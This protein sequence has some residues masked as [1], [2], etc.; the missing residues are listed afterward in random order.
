MT[1][2]R[3]SFLDDERLKLLLFGG[4]GGVGKT[5]MAAAT[6]LYQARRRPDWRILAASTDPAHSLSDSFNQHIG[7]EVMPIT[8]LPNLFAHE[9]NAERHGEEFK[10]RHEE[11]LK[12]IL[13]R[14]TY[15]DQEDIA[16]FL[17]LSLPGLDELMAVV[18]VADI[19][20]EKQYNLVILDTAP[21]GHTLRL[22]ALPQ[23]LEEWLHV[24]DLMLDKHRYI[25]STFGRVRHDEA[26]S[27]L[28][29]MA[30]KLDRLRAVLSDE[31]ST[32]FVPVTIPE[33]MSI[34]ETADLL[35]SLESLQIGVRSLVVNQV[36][37][38][39]E[40]AFCETRHKGQERYLEEIKNRFS[41][42]TPVPAPLMP[43]EVRGQQ[44][45]EEYIQA[46]LG[47]ELPI[48]QPQAI[49]LCEIENE[50]GGIS[51]V[52]RQ[53]L[54]LFGG[55]GGV[56]K[57]TIATATAIHL[58]RKNPGQKNL[59]FSTDPAHSLSDSLGQQ[60]G[61]QITAV[62]GVEGLFALELDAGEQLEE[63]KRDYRTAINELFDAFLGDSFDI[64][65]D[66]LVMEELITLTPPGLDEL[67]GLTTIMDFLEKGE[68]DHYIM[69]MAPTGHALRF[70][71]MPGLV[72]KWFITMFK[73]LLKYQDVTQLP[74]AAELLQKKSKHL[75]RLQKLLNDPESCQLIAVTIP[76]TMAV[77][78]TER[79]LHQLDDL[80][81]PC[82]RVV[83]NMVM[84]QTKCPFCSI[85][86][87]EQRHSLKNLHDLCPDLV[88]V[89]LQ[90]HEIRGVADLANI[91]KTLYGGS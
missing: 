20:E 71:E 59:L 91:A 81:V 14:G 69:D 76:Q 55:K 73:L 56:G 41:A 23:L 60:I 42:C 35:K 30:A 84:P 51:I 65:Y 12:T 67:M 68:F 39:S 48:P 54:F 22:L 88:Q 74:G 21:T 79:L 33:A 49:P 87:D 19:V 89:P 16:G 44:A 40:C 80:S 52:E 11:V 57:T 83:V 63:L 53:Q 70:L 46:V 24:F 36:V 61:S 62:D 78:E 75:R 47:H 72:R 17:N 58:T 77:L 27:F 18:E 85:V 13:D 31:T 10:R 15:F 8:G 32:E 90:P 6:A 5:T 7:D 1:E 28:E 25:A 37:T 82:K 26:D 9:M 38:R 66:R 4:K 29:D 45:L 3:I 2:Q 64:P 34:E 50:V 43:R 86:R